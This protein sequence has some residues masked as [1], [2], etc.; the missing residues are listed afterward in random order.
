MFA[1]DGRQKTRPLLHIKDAR[2]RFSA[3]AFLKDSSTTTIWNTFV[4]I[5][6]SVY[7]EFPGSV[8]PD[9]GSVFLSREWKYNC[10][11]SRIYLLNTGTESHSSLGTAEKYHSTLRKMYR[12]V[13]F[14]HLKMPDG[15]ALAKSVQAMNETVGAHGLVPTLLAFEVIPKLPYISERD[16]PAQRARL[17]A[18]CNARKEYEKS[19]AKSIVQ[20]SLRNILSQQQHARNALKLQ[21]RTYST[22]CP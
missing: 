4:R 16:F 10:E 21:N 5:W 9:Q 15:I 13:L 22:T 3:A 2:S 18:A 1:K 17:R 14:D 8:L 6:S 11:C 7:I 12:K 20:R 19:I